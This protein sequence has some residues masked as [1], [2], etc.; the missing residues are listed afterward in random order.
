[1][2][3]G[4]KE[5]CNYTRLHT[6]C[7]SGEKYIV[8]QAGNIDPVNGYLSFPMFIY[9]LQYPHSVFHPFSFIDLPISEISRQ[10]K[11]THTLPCQAWNNMSLIQ[12]KS[13]DST[14]HYEIRIINKVTLKSNIKSL[15][16]RINA[17]NLVTEPPNN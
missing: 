4:R 13:N 3:T 2:C 10:K 15:T 9:F 7:C 8:T 16:V 17:R 1:M 6:E 14:F 11:H 12:K 5:L